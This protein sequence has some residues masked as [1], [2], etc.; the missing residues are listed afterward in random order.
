MIDSGT[1]RAA[2]A[3]IN[4]ALEGIRTCEDLC[5]FSLNDAGLAARLKAL[6]HDVAS[7]AKVFDYMGLL[8]A[9][10]TGRDTIRFA[11]TS[12]E[13]T[14]LS[15]ADV[16]AAGMKRAA[17]ALRSL[18]EFRK[19]L[20]D[21]GAN[22]FQTHR[23]AVYDIEKIIV[24]ALLRVDRVSRVRGSLYAILDSAFV[25]EGRYAETAALMA[26]G[27]AGIIQLRMKE[28]DRRDVLKAARDTAAALKGT[29]VLFI[30]NDYPDIALLSG[31]DGVHLG[32]GDLAASDARQILT[33]G[34]IIGLSTNSPETAA[35]AMKE[36]PDYIAVGPVFGTMSKTEAPLP[37]VGCGV[38]SSVRKIT[39]LPIVAI[40]GINPGNA[41]EPLKAGADS[42]AV[43]SALYDQGRVKENCGFLSA[44]ISEIY[45]KPDPEALR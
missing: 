41:G 1:Y 23:F 11:D 25:K 29:G 7:A 39:E 22:P 13:K 34:M 5:R 30:V 32:G 9:R 21:S 37:A 35:F 10:D 16:A 15:A 44:L 27:G 24:P 8:S 19:L 43:I 33:P 18:E 31:A 38:I 36:Q 45:I 42:L 4:R 14:R 12:A 2:D 40:G 28:A 6:R 26:A 20:P 3:C 17:Q